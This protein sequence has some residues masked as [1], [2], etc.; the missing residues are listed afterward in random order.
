MTDTNT[1]TAGDAGAG[2]SAAP[3]TPDKLDQVLTNTNR[4]AVAIDEV[5]AVL[6]LLVAA[7]PMTTKMRRQFAAG[8]EAAG[9]D[10][11]VWVL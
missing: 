7:A 5:R 2:T 3:A 8:L 4:T 11:A 6:R 1:T 9:I 10:P